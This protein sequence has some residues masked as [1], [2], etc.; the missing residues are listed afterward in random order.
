MYTLKLLV[1]CSREFSD[2]V[3]IEYGI[4]EGPKGGKYVASRYILEY[5]VKNSKIAELTNQY[6][7]RDVILL[8]ANEYGIEIRDI[9][10]NLNE[11][12]Y[13]SDIRD[14]GK[15]LGAKVLNGDADV[16]TGLVLATK[17]REFNFGK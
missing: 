17:L 12:V 6:N 16:D 13:M 10:S 14:V 7:V 5:M 9:M 15:R 2:E 3:G 8:V 4:I 1:V 11:V